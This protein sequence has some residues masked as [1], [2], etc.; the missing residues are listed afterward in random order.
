MLQLV[1]EVV[2]AVVGIIPTVIFRAK[3]IRSEGG[4]GFSYVIRASMYLIGYI[5]VRF[6]RPA[7]LSYEQFRQ[8]EGFRRKKQRADIHGDGILGGLRRCFS[9]E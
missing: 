6:A 2:L 9:E 1:S 4:Y 7:F 3:G 8:N 5:C